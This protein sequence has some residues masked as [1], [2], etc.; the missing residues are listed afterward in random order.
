MVKFALGLWC[1]EFSISIKRLCINDYDS[2][3]FYSRAILGAEGSLKV[4]YRG[5]FL[6]IFLI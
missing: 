1:R 5:I 4:H 6:R 3:T 2:G